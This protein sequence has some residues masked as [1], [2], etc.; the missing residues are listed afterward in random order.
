L[1]NAPQ[2]YFKFVV[3][4]ETAEDVII[5]IEN[6]IKEIPWYSDIFLMPLGETTEILNKNA[7]PAAKLAIKKGW[8]YSDRLHIRLWEDEMSR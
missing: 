2:S 5:E 8:K 3:N 7:L 6:I 4:G 1:E